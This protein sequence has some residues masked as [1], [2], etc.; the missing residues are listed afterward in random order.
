MNQFVQR[1]AHYI[2]NELLVKGLA[3]SKTFQR[4]VV[5]T[6]R[7]IQKYKNEGLEQVNTHIDEL[8]KKATQA[9]YSTST[10]SNNY[11][12]SAT[13]RGKGGLEPPQKPLEASQDFLVL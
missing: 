13:S 10:K 7:H 11:S 6:D 1:V 2:A 12:A 8:H 4:F 5:H 3:E 9:A